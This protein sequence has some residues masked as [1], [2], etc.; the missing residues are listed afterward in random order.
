MG[1]VLHHLRVVMDLLHHLRVVMDLGLEG[2]L[3]EVGEL[4]E[5]G[6]LSIIRRVG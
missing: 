4:Q 2:V 6:K 5:D 1:R 3:P